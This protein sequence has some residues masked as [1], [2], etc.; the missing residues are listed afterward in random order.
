[1]FFALKGENFNGNTFAEDAISKGAAFAII[2]D[3]KYKINGQYLLVD[4]VLIA[5]QNLAL[6]HRKYLNIPIISLTG[7]NGKTTTN[8]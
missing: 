6:F 5:L 2:D 4:D 3:I 7:S 8:L 1:M